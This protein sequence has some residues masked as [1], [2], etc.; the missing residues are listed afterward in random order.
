MHFDATQIRRDF[1]ILGQ[2]VHGKPLVYLDSGAS[3]QKPQA[4]IDA[5]SQYYERDNANIH[6]GVYELSRRATEAYEAAHETVAEFIGAADAREVIFTRGTTEAIN[7]LTYTLFPLLNG[8]TEVLLTEMEHHA[9][10]VPWQQM[11]QRHGLTVRYVKVTPDYRLDMDDLNAKLTERTGVFAFTHISNVLGTVNEAA[12]LCGMARQVGAVSVV[13]GAQAAPHRA[14][15]VAAIGCDFYAFSSHKM[16]GPTGLGVLYGRRALLEQMDPFQTG[17]D[18]IREVTFEAST[19]N[20]LPMK[21]EPGTP[22]IAGAVG[23]DAAVR[24]LQAIGMDA[25]DVWE[26][27][28]TTYGLATLSAIDGVRVFHPGPEHGSGILS[29]AVDGVHPHDLAS[30]LNDDGICVRAG[31]HCAQPLMGCLGVTATTRA[32]FYLYNTRADVDA[33]A[34]SVRR[35][36]DLLRGK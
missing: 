21:F 20:D 25:V 32:S 19:W 31:H 1:P 13:D 15:D 10:I 24:Y 5:V 7:L 17:G 4:V 33:L 28:L 8:R 30:L 35:A 3:A 16:L 12:T 11:A 9:N 23:L 18:M 34:A 26:R 14:V 29:F 22:H 36:A 27:E 2:T 6:R